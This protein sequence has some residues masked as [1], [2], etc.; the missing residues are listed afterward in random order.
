MKKGNGGV[1]NAKA[2]RL[3]AESARREAE[4]HEYKGQRT[5]KVKPT[6]E[7]LLQEVLAEPLCLNLV[8]TFGVPS[9]G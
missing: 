4:M 2:L 3:G 1:R 6:A 7:D 5:P 9:A 8:G